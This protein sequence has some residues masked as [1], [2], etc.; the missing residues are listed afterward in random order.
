MYCDSGHLPLS[1]V[2]PATPEGVDI[3]LE[4]AIVCT[5][6]RQMYFFVSV[7]TSFIVHC[8]RPCVCHVLPLLI[9]GL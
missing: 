1:S 8:L 6:A 5:C 7:C 2:S 9:F 4:L 3:A